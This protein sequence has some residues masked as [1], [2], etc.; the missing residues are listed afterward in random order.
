MRASFAVD[1]ALLSRRKP[2]SSPSP[3]EERLP[4]RLVGDTVGNSEDIPKHF[5][6]ELTTMGPDEPNGSANSTHLLT[7]HFQV[8]H[9]SYLK[10]DDQ[11]VGAPKIPIRTSANMASRV[12]G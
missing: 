10:P 3:S 11:G 8:E 6:T 7:D 5:D 4:Q 2:A 12:S 9:L 1:D